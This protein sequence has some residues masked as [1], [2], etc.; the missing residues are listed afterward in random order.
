MLVFG[1]PLPRHSL[2]PSF[3]TFNRMLFCALVKIISRS[4]LTSFLRHS[5]TEM[6]KATSRR[7]MVRYANME[8]RGGKER[9]DEPTT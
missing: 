8:V 2:F 6:S 4:F 9:S 1:H 7:Q 5:R 3:S